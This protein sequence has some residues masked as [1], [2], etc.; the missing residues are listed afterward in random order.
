[1]RLFI[2]ICLLLSACASHETRCDR[3]L[4]PINLPAPP[5]AHAAADR[6]SDPA[7]GKP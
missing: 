1:M 7:A 3:H 5:F 2:P 6:A 4:Q